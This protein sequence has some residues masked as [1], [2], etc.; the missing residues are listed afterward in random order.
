M[1]FEFNQY[2]N[3]L[4]IERVHVIFIARICSCWVHV[5]T[6]EGYMICECWLAITLKRDYFGFEIG[7]GGGNSD[8]GGDTVVFFELTKSTDISDFFFLSLLFLHR[9]DIM[10]QRARQC[11]GANEH[12][13]IKR[14]SDVTFAPWLSIQMYAQRQQ[15]HSWHFCHHI[16][17][18]VMF[19]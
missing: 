12:T 19:K 13:Q 3:W 7:D 8:G 9:F 16:I 6:R 4:V 14:W 18:N 17:K 1:P 2:I 15:K 5:L 11:A 10:V